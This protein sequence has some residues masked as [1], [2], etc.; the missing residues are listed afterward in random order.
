MAAAVRAGLPCLG[1]CLGMQLFFD[2]S[3]EA[4][5]N[6]AGLGIIPGR[7][8]RLDAQRV[9]Q[10]GWNS[11][12]PSVPSLLDAAPLD[13]VYYANSYVCRPDDESV[14]QA[15]STHDGDR[16]PAIVRHANAVGTQFH[17]EKSSTPGLRFLQAFLDETRK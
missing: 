9:P 5:P 13:Y 12:E 17:P 1:I 14:V 7:V 16:F 15:W 8:T 10:I 2:A 6:E 3:D 11:L 4:A